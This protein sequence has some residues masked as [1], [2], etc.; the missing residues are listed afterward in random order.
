LFEYS[1]GYQAPDQAFRTI[2]AYDCPNVCP[3]I[4]YFSNPNVIYQGQPTGI[5]YGQNPGQAADN[6]R[7]I[8]ESLSTVANWRVKTVPL[9]DAPAAP[10]NLQATAVSF[11][12]ILLTWHNL[13]DNADGIIVERKQMGG[14]WS[15]VAVLPPSSE[16]YTNRGLASQVEYS[17]RLQAYNLGG[18][19]GYSNEAS[20]Q[21]EA[22]A[23]QL[24]FPLFLSD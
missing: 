14:I 2:M 17:Y 7:S 15:Q 21:T 24:L 19:S 11:S 3:R 9:P 12:E 13:A 8:N 22:A 18:S 16:T 6:A 4:Q 5:D 23:A 1:F 10:S 20:A